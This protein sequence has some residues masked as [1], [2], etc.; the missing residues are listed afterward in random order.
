VALAALA[1]CQAQAPTVAPQDASGA[2]NPAAGS[3][4]A[5][6]SPFDGR[7]NAI[8]KTAMAIT[9]D[10]TVK[11]DAITSSLGHSWTTAA[12]PEIAADAPLNAAGD[13]LKGFLALEDEPSLF[14]AVKAI[15]AET[16][17]A[18]AT[19]GGLCGQDKATY[20]AFVRRLD[21]ADA[22]DSALFIAAFTGAGPPGPASN[23]AICATYTF[24]QTEG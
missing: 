9:G 2:E 20:I 16:V 3:R 5:G 7:F 22:H 14:V 13:T 10:L 15:T 1:G 19:N 18:T 24:Q 11:G 8:S 23:L 12:G 4:L 21:P 6:A 17:P